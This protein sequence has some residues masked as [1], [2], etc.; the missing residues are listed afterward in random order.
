MRSRKGSKLG[1]RRESSPR[2]ELHLNGEMDN[3]CCSHRCTSSVHFGRGRVGAD[4]TCAFRYCYFSSFRR[5]LRAPL[6]Q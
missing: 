5:F 6:P 2:V 3:F 4:H 1:S